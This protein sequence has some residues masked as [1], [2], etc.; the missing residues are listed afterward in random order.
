MAFHRRESS[1]AEPHLNALSSRNTSI[2]TKPEPGT[3]V[4]AINN[5]VTRSGFLFC[6]LWNVIVGGMFT[7]MI[8]E[9]NSRTS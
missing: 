7:F 6:L 8:M 2:F 9:V 3:L 5:A 1:D 4:V